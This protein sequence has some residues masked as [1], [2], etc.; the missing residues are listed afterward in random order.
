V[1]TKG[2]AQRRSGQGVG[3]QPGHLRT[4]GVEVAAQD[5]CRIRQAF[6]GIPPGARG[7]ACSSCS[8]RGTRS[9]A[10]A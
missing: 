6:S 4:L 3:D 7:A 8:R 9:F 1:L 10:R 5:E 2:L